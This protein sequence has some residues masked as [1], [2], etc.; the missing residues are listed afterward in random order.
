M[1]L[2]TSRFE[3][4]GEAFFTRLHP[5]PLPAPYWVGRSNGLARA[6]DLPEDWHEQ[7]QHLEA[8]T[9]NCL[10]PGSSPLASVYSGH[11]FGQWAGQ[12]GDGRAILLGERAAPGGPQEI[13]LKG[14]G[15]TP[16][17]RMGDG[18]AVLRSSIR[19]F[20]CSE[21]MHALGIPTTRALCV[22][23]SNAPVR[24]EEIE[25]A[26]VVTR[27]APS[28]IRF[29][30]FEHF[31]HTG[32]HDAL[33][34]LADFVIDHFYPECRQADGNPYARL[35]EAVSARTAELL[36]QWQAVG[37]C[38]GVMNTDNMSILGLTIDYGPFQ[39]MDAFDPGH[40]C[41]HS[42]NAGRYA[43]ARQPNI[44][45]WNLFCL[46]QA[47]LPL[48]EDT[49][50]ALDAL[51][52][53]KALFP[54]ALQRRMGAKLGLTEVQEGDAALTE[55]LMQLLARDRVDFTIFWRRLSHAV[56]G[57]A[58][59][60]HTPAEAEHAITPVRDLFLQREAF[61]AWALRWR[62]RLQAQP[63]FDATTTRDAML[64]TN[65]QV[66]L[67]NHL[68]EIAIHHARQGDFSVLER[69]QAALEQPYAALP[70]QE[71]L[72]AFPPDWA[73]QIQISCSS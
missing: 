39:F 59:P 65:P 55:D 11:Q 45:Y 70:G 50:Q 66:V 69:L 37:F 8:L 26:A 47:M 60:G 15:L 64:R 61:D 46:G 33:R 68:G 52:P 29:G 22:T 7:P 34:L 38:H 19:E 36:A 13:Q 2:Q 5:T 28:F 71:D 58:A 3:T 57:F 56:A 49:Q 42:D 35:L 44:A 6:L 18:R 9:G 25:T 20:L 21:A 40:I 4:L 24:R 62:A 23:G 16:Y 67:R 27:V 12:L 54:A 43:Y 63:G 48:M 10:L 73:T 72:A 30:H 17:S 1:E 53:Y 32:Q 51:E 14:A 41:N 31:C